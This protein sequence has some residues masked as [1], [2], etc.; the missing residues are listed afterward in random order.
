MLQLEDG[1]AF[2]V[3]VAPTFGATLTFGAGIFFYHIVQLMMKYGFVASRS[4][5]IVFG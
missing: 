3:G 4:S 1:D 5:Y 2:V